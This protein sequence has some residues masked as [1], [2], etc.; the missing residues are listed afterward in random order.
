MALRRY[1]FPSLL[2]NTI[3]SIWLQ[4]GVSVTILEKIITK[5]HPEFIIK[6]FDVL[7]QKLDFYLGFVQI[8]DM[9]YAD[10]L[11]KS[12]SALTYFGGI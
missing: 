7:F 6:Y 8:P 12:S 10:T 3:T 5:T 11:V 9:I 4:N 2:I 1:E